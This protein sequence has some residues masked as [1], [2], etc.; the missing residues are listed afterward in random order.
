M[1]SQTVSAIIQRRIARLAARFN[2]DAQP[3]LVAVAD[4]AQAAATFAYGGGRVEPLAGFE[5]RAVVWRRDTPDDS[6]VW[7]HPADPHRAIFASFIETAYGA[8][9]WTGF[10]A[11]DVDHVF[12]K[13]RAPAGHFLLLEA[14]PLGDNRSHGGGFERTNTASTIEKATAG[15]EYRKL[16]F[17]SVL[18]L[19][20][21]KPPR[22]LDDRERINPARDW[23]V[24]NGWSAREVEDAIETLLTKAAWR[25]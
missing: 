21:L 20:G 13:A 11:F 9:D 12:N 6:S 1:A 15:R 23:L 25:K 14:I 16:T 10:S 19:A 3:P 5:G 8:V 24:R 18:K 4:V 22:A 17:V 7:A 2:A